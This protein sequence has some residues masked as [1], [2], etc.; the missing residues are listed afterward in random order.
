MT[1]VHNKKKLKF[2]GIPFGQSVHNP[3]WQ[4]L[5][6]CSYVGTAVDDFVLQPDP[7]LD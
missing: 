1:N 3:V 4:H 6:E 5:L 7:G 2:V